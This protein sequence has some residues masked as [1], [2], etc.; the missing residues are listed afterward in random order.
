MPPSTTALLCAPQLHHTPPKKTS[1]F[2][3]LPKAPCLP[4]QLHF[5]VLPSY[6]THHQ[7]KQVLSPL[8]QKPHA[9][10]Y[11]C[12]SLCS[13]ATPHTTKKN[14]YF[15]HS[16]KSPMP[17]ST[18]ALLCAPQLHH[19]PPKKTS[20]FTTLPKAP[21]LPLQLHFSVLPSYTTHH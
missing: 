17:P 9:S 21:C 16:T 6:T 4:L 8:Y 20:T 15:H 19:T 2:T 13:P 7:K 10:L 5:S 1:T 11:N 14:K 3:T 12:T 18:T